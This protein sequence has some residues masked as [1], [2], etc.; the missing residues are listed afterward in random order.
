MSLE[1][2]M[3][4]LTCM[5]HKLVSSG[6]LLG[7]PHTL[8]AVLKGHYSG[9]CNIS[10]IDLAQSLE[11]QHSNQQS[12][13]FL[14]VSDLTTCYWTWSV[15]MWF[16]DITCSGH[17]TTAIKGMDPWVVW[18]GSCGLVQSTP[19]SLKVGQAEWH[20][21]LLSILAMSY[22]SLISFAQLVG[23]C[24]GWCSV[25]I[26]FDFAICEK[27]VESC[28]MPH[29]YKYCKFVHLPLAAFPPLPL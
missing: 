11:R 15:L 24:G 18:L 20:L 2:I 16:L 17:A 14:I 28:R 13:L 27:Y 22:N 6:N 4:C 21:I 19:K 8:L 3:T 9:T 10:W 29:L 23:L 7:H 26:Y 5:T 25:L 12:N 1:R